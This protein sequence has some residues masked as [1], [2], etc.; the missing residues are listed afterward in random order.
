M[1]SK[2]LSSLLNYIAISKKIVS[3]EV[4]N[5]FLLVLIFST[6]C[7]LLELFSIGLLIPIFNFFLNNQTDFLFNKFN[8]D[9]N[10]TLNNLII[11]V[12]IIFTCKSFL[13]YLNNKFQ[14]KTVYKLSERLSKKIY[15]LNLKKNLDFFLK[16]NTSQA[17]RDVYNECY[18]FSNGVVLSFIKLLSDLI[19]L[20]FF[21]VFLLFIN[22]KITIIITFLL[23][24]FAFSYFLI[25]RGKLNK[26]GQERQFHESQRIK[27]IREGFESFTFLKIFNLNKFFTDKYNIHNENSHDIFTKERVLSTI[28]KIIL[29]LLI[30]VIFCLILYF[31]VGQKLNEDLIILELATFALISFRLL[32]LFN[33]ILFCFQQLQ[34]N[35]SVIKN[36]NKIF[37]E[38]ENS[39][40]LEHD[41]I[42]FDDVKSI[43]FKNITFNYLPSDNVLQNVNFKLID[44]GLVQVTGESGSGKTTLINLLMGLLKQTS[45]EILI[46]NK[47][48]NQN[49]RIRDLSY[50]PQKTFL[51]N[52]TIKSNIIMDKDYEKK[53]FEDV[54]KSANLIEFYKKNENSFL[55]NDFVA[56]SLSGGQQQRLSLARALYRE[57]KILIL[58]EPLSS[59][60][61]KNTDEIIETFKY[62]KNNKEIL[63]ILVSHL[64]LPHNIIDLELEIKDLTIFKK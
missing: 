7:A 50:V 27:F 39:I 35:F 29:E 22:I 38:Y 37:I 33:S 60:D 14:F 18:I 47:E 3:R 13:I 26:I 64:K 49:F 54:L 32:P 44:K 24:F 25:I 30:V 23:I 28:P 46:N 51:F 58:D 31:A 61:K 56:T 59:L 6:F 41:S 15:S 55:N 1:K 12:I 45:G 43:E 9:L 17:I 20:T 8:I 21:F 53:L 52:D 36:L 62:I 63:I 57:P 40:S 11:L 2:T 16:G 10:F 19:L 4:P 34:F 5:K 42:I 48:V